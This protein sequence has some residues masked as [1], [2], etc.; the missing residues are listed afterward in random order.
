MNGGKN[1]MRNGAN[2][3][4]GLTLVEVLVASSIGVLMLGVT[5]ALFIAAQR[6]LENAMAEV[7]LSFE[8]RMLRDKLLFRIDDKGGLM[9]ARRSG[10]SVSGGGADRGT[11]I[12]YRPFVPTGTEPANTIV[13][14][15]GNLSANSELAS[16][17]LSRGQS[18][19]VV[20]SQ[21]FSKE[22]SDGEVDIDAVL[23]LRVGD[24]NY[25]R[26]QRILAQIVSR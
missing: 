17:W 14:S 21:P 6:S 8:S 23:N 16:G 24:R 10:L 26:R 19:F 2:R 7:Q 25:T 9:S 5:I 15:S 11:S 4:D 13:L 3:R 1:Q 12:E 20:G 22:F 18:Q